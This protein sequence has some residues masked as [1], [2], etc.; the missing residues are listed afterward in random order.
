MLKFMCIHDFQLEGVD[1]VGGKVISEAA[2]PPGS[3]DGLLRCGHV[4]P[5]TNNEVESDTISRAAE[6]KAVREAEEREAERL[7]AEEKKSR[8]KAAAEEKKA[9]AK[10]ER[11]A[12]ERESKK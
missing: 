5:A 3:L 2:I 11:E 9:K 4:R 8:A 10:A 1:H 12:A 6:E 7:A